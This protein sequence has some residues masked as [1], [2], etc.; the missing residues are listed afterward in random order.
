M[1]MPR[2]PFYGCPPSGDQR[3]PLM[4]SRP[5]TKLSGCGFLTLAI[6]SPVSDM[7]RT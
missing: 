6:T 7:W 2:R 4:N 3:V 5:S 1:K